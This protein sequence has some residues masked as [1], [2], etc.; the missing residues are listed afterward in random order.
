MNKE[1]LL[2]KAYDSGL[3]DVISEWLKD[4]KYV[5]ISS[6]VEAFS[7]G[8]IYSQCIFQELIRLG[9][10]EEKS[11]YNRGNRV[12][13]YNPVVDMK[14]Y[15]LDIN[16]KIGDALKKEFSEF[17]EVE[18]IID[19]FAHFMNVYKDIEC[20]VSP[21]NSFG[22]M[23]G[24]YDKAITDYFG[25]DV[26]I[27]VR[28]F[29]NKNLFGEQPVGTSIMVNIPNTNKKLIHTPTM[30]LP[31]RILDPMVIYH[32]MRSTM[33]MAINNRIH[34]IVI[35]AFGGLTGQVEPTVL[36]KYM[37]MGYSQVTDFLKK[38]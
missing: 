36:A 11:F 33:I 29:I 13:I 30:R 31:S 10:V 34:S 38:K 2:K 6:I 26:Q 1:T 9:L 7:I 23:N 15:L 5:S 19:D 16:K 14:V 32:C 4:Q 21:A 17:E 20:V 12:L 22:I 3:I 24:G 37:R 35:P 28:K 8:Y 25:N 18:V 27:E